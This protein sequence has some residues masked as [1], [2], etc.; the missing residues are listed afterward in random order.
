MT[1][2]YGQDQVCFLFFPPISALPV[3][4]IGHEAN[5]CGLSGKTAP[6]LINDLLDYD[7]IK[8]KN[9]GR[10]LL[11]D[12]APQFRGKPLLRKGIQDCRHI[13]MKKLNL[14]NTPVSND[15]QP[16]GTTRYEIATYCSI[17]RHH[18]DISVDFRARYGRH[19]PCR[20]SDQENPLHHLRLVE[21]ADLKE[22][23]Q[24]YGSYNRYHAFTEAHKFECSGATC[25]VEVNIKISPPRLGKKMLSL[26][27]DPKKVYA[28][29]RKV[30]QEEPER[31]NGFSPISPYQALTNLRTYLHDARDAKDPEKLKKI[32]K[33]NK[34]LL[35]G[36][37]DECDSLFDYLD[38]K[39]VSEDGPDPAVVCSFTIHFVV[40]PN[41]S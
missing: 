20:L 7:P 5:I 15:E 32:A 14:S 19:I 1:A 12:D 40:I 28:R 33:R 31:F 26:I 30:I 29:G 39:V 35:L 10:N 8:L 17:C 21:S 38:F 3:A 11:V 2:P 27:T 24:R 36:F 25:P 22:Y 41:A 9:N 23:E 16:D 13:L 18:F 4:D 37:A 6:R 34:R